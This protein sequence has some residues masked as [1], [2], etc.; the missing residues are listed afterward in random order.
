MKKL[1]LLGLLLAGSGNLAAASAPADWQQSTAPI[2]SIERALDGSVI[3]VRLQDD[4]VIFG[5]RAAELAASV[6]PPGTYM[7][8]PAF[9]PPLYPMDAYGRPM[10]PPSYGM[11][12]P[13]PYGAPVQ[14]LPMPQ[15]PRAMA[16]AATTPATPRLRALAT[17]FV[18]PAAV[19]AA[20]PAATTPP[21][22]IIVT[23]APAAT[24]VT[25]VTTAETPT[26]VV[27]PP[28]ETAAIEKEMEAMQ[29]EEANQRAAEKAAQEAAAAAKKAKTEAKKARLGKE[30]A[31]AAAAKVIAD[32]Q[33]A[34]RAAAEQKAA[35]KADA[36]KRAADKAAMLKAQAEQAAEAAKV[37]ADKAKEEAKKAKEEKN[38]ADAAAA[39]KEKADAK[40]AEQAR[41]VE[42]AKALKRASQK[43]AASATTTLSATSPTAACAKPK[44]R[45][46]AA[47][48]RDK[49]EQEE[50][51][52][53]TPVA[54]KT[55]DVAK[56]EAKIAKLE[57]TAFAA[58][59][60]DEKFY[61]LDNLGRVASRV[62][63]PIAALLNTRPAR[64]EH[65]FYQTA[66]D[67]MSRFI[68]NMQTTD[69][70]RLLPSREDLQRL[71]DTLDEMEGKPKQT[72]ESM[73]AFMGFMG[74][75]D[76]KRAIASQWP[77]IP[78]GAFSPSAAGDGEVPRSRAIAQLF[79]GGPSTATAETGAAGGVLLTERV[80]RHREMYEREVNYIRF[81]AFVDN[82]KTLLEDDE[83]DRIQATVDQFIKEIEATPYGLTA[84]EL[85]KLE[86]RASAI[87]DEDPAVRAEKYLEQLAIFIQ[88][89][90]TAIKT[91]ATRR[92]RS[93]PTHRPL[94][95]FLVP[96]LVRDM[97]AE[98]RRRGAS[99]KDNTK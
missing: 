95:E 50:A 22:P 38:K 65:E 80:D 97:I 88:T 64:K 11:P 10:M 32:K 92:T 61:I 26:I 17:E 68:N 3:S 16:T 35:K 1:L 12:M 28:A 29:L 76:A 71:T 43:A 52:T 99:A 23:S 93:T 56:L 70:L 37:A 54:E 72:L 21:T 9:Y 19:A 98:H 4:T 90:T 27:T 63:K 5:P 36:E 59:Q 73:G 77:S 30:R 96:S 48:R 8:P 91:E 49:K 82:V 24:P 60:T 87:G 18:P 94:E 79:V 14:Y 66:F 34:D 86:A 67:Q 55:I 62:G 45:T 58:T 40:V 33:I 74:L 41:A 7:M 81:S 78:A 2:K 15:Y 46:I 13:P 69:D 53:S 25:H 47:F 42:E 44:K 20:A 84:T 31:D 75:I 89:K 39:K 83:K 51:A 6:V 85:A 57:A